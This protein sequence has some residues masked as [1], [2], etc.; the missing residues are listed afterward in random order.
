MYSYCCCCCCFLMI[1][2]L[3][4]ILLL[5]WNSFFVWMK[6]TNAQY[7]NN[8]GRPGSFFLQSFFVFLFNE[9]KFMICD[10][11]CILGKIFSL[12]TYSL[13]CN[14]NESDNYIIHRKCHHHHQVI[15]VNENEKSYPEWWWWWWFFVSRPALSFKRERE[16]WIFKVFFLWS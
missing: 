9:M 8:T 7:N 15:I 14:W 5:S 6:W 12:I 4:P 13:L 16:K 10:I 11:N 2:S 1:R 3:S